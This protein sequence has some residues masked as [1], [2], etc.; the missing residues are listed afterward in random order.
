M[1]KPIILQKLKTYETSSF[2]IAY[3]YYSILFVVNNLKLTEREL[4]LVSFTGINGNISYT[5]LREEFCNT[6]GSS[7]A[8]INNMISKLK[9]QNILIKDSSKIKV[10]PVI[11][12]KFY[13]NVKLELSISIFPEV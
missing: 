6:Y 9:K 13:D 10:N 8:S 3:K 4:Q 11:L 1:E 2:D 7:N 12:L 5:H